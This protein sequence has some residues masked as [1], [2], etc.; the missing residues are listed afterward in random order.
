MHSFC[1]AVLSEAKFLNQ[2][3]AEAPSVAGLTDIGNW[4]ILHTSAVSSHTT[5]NPCMIAGMHKQYHVQLQLQSLQLIPSSNLP[6]DSISV[7]DGCTAATGHDIP[8][9][10]ASF[11]LQ[12]TVADDT[13]SLDDTL[14][15]TG[16]MGC[17]LVLFLCHAFYRVSFFRRI[18]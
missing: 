8:H 5:A 2:Y 10:V 1:K 14:H 6:Q 15:N 13:A 12:H 18:Q 9:Q 16:D 7:A 11:S 3:K 4:S 17:L